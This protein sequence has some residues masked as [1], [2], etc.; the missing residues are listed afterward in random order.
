M[1]TIRVESA[2]LRIDGFY[3]VDTQV[4]SY[5]P[6]EWLWRDSGS[7]PEILND[8]ATG[9]FISEAAAEKWLKT[10]EAAE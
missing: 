8:G 7:G 3:V 10:Y 9:P 2:D 6:S 1:E 5:G 4:T